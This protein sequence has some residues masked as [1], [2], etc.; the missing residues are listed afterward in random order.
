MPREMKIRHIPDSVEAIQV[1]TV[2]SVRPRPRKPSARTEAE[3]D[4]PSCP[5]VSRITRLMALAIKFQGMIERGELRDYADI[6]RV[7][8]VVNSWT[9]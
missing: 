5:Q 6:A 9:R 3:P 2:L 4:A 7:W 1:E 8:K